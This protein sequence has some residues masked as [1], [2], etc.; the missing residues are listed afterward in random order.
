MTKFYLAVIAFVLLSVSSASAQSSAVARAC[1]RDVVA[2]CD[3]ARSDKSRL[4][5][6]VKAR[7][8]D[9]SEPCKAEIT[10]TAAVRKACGKDVAERCA[11]AGMGAGRLLLCVKQNYYGLSEPCKD[12]IGLAAQKRLK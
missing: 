7:F 12:A 11:T 3:S 4:A 10:K 5:E 1:G 8:A 9:F 6:C 2:N